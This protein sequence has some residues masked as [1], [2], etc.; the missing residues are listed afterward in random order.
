MQNI[1]NYD[2]LVFCVPHH[3]TL[4][5]EGAFLFF[6][7]LKKVV[8]PINSELNKIE[9]G[10]FSDASITSIFILPKI[11]IL[12]ENAFSKCEKLQIVEFDENSKLQHISQELFSDSIN[13][14]LMIPVNL[15]DRIDANP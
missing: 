6:N 2:I 14:I 1:E 11:T 15:N 12:G 4:I 7:Q 9:H 8:I 3:L 10:S 13:A 5:C